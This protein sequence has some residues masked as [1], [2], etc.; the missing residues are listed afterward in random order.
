MALGQG[1]DL[2]ANCKHSRSSEE[3]HFT[4]ANTQVFEQSNKRIAEYLPIPTPKNTA[5]NAYVHTLFLSEHKQDAMYKRTPVNFD[6]KED[7]TKKR[8]S[9]PWSP[10]LTIAETMTVHPPDLVPLRVQ[11]VNPALPDRKSVV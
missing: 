11:A 9:K 6:G 3:K 10:S 8:R 4:T 1:I 7:I 2:K 5:N